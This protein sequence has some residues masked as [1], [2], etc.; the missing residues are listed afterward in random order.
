MSCVAWPTGNRE[1]FDLVQHQGLGSAFK[2]FTPLRDR[3]DSNAR[4]QWF[5]LAGLS[6]D[7][8]SL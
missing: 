8:R 4:S 6:L 3:K 7:T 5:A 1:A 2:Q